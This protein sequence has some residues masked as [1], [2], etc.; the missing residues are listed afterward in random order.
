MIG[1]MRKRFTFQVFFS[2]LFSG[3]FLAPPIGWTANSATTTVSNSKLNALQLEAKFQEAYAKIGE[4]YIDRIQSITFMIGGF[5]ELLTVPGVEGLKYQDLVSPTQHLGSRKD[6]LTAFRTALQV[7]RSRMGG[8]VELDTLVSAMIRGMVKALN[9]DYSTYLEPEKNRELVRFLKGETK[10]FGGIGVQIQFK[11]GLCKVTRP[12]PDT[13]AY[14]AGIRPGDVVV[15][16]DGKEV[17]TEDEAVDRMKG[18]PGSRVAVTIQREE[19]AEPLTYDLIRQTISQPELEKILLPGSVGYVRLNSFNETS[20]KQL[21]EN[22][23]YLDGQGMKQCIL[24]L[25]QNSGGLLKSAVEISA[26]FLPKGSLVVSTKGRQP[27]DTKE[28]RTRD[29]YPY[30][31]LPLVVLV[32]Q[33]TASA[34]EIVTGA[35]RDNRRGKVVGLTTFGKGTVQE[36]I[37]LDDDSALKLTVAKYYTP[38]G[39]CIHKTGIKPDY[40]VESKK[41]INPALFEEPS[42]IDLTEVSEDAQIKK[43]L[44][45]FNVTLPV[46]GT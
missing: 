23:N 3:L 18:E 40:H 10:S 26:I 27:N 30:A 39:E 4:R 46:Q 8:R 31:R 16:V 5:R 29:T 15:Q 37:P 22:L 44:D 17:T 1:T 24:D 33:F 35:V 34:A 7:I 9:D 6:D 21:I 36:V 45:L 2:L 13:P 41:L 12:I 25:R 19:V 43:A 32:D 14:R 28:Y 20:A 11:D 42:D 38:I